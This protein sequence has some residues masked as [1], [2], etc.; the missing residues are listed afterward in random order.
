MIYSIGYE[1]ITL[2]DLKRVMK[3]Y[4]IGLVIDVRSIPYAR[5]AKQE[6]NRNKLAEHFGPRYEWKGNILGGKTGPALEAG[7]EYLMRQNGKKSNILLCVENDPKRCHRFYDIS[8]RLLERGI[9]II[10]IYDGRAV[11]TTELKKEAI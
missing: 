7:I 1:K 2:P 4:H 5:V 11:S 10:H 3:Q 9:E 6:F 8:V